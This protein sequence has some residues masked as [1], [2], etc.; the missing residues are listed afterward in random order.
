MVS[1]IYVVIRACTSPAAELSVGLGACQQVMLLE[2]EIEVSWRSSEKFPDPY[3][4]R[5]LPARMGQAR[6]YIGIS[7][8]RL[9]TLKH[10]HVYPLLGFAFAVLSIESLQLNRF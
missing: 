9:F 3:R 7:G 2:V 1:S 8:V 6:A 5:V 4:R 10:A